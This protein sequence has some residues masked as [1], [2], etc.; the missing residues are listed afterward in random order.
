MKDKI[1]IEAEDL[2]K[3]TSN[4]KLK[5][6]EGCVDYLPFLFDDFVEDLKFIEPTLT[7]KAIF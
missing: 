1:K 2:V 6:K 7:E 4:E 3:E 5:S